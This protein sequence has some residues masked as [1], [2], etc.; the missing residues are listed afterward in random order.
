MYKEK[1]KDTQ[2][3]LTKGKSISGTAGKIIGW[4]GKWGAN[5][6]FALSSNCEWWVGGIIIF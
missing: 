2:K 3:I 6:S 5:I 1:R 4:N